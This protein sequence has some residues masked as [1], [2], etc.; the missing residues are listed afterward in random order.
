VDRLGQICADTLGP[1]QYSGVGG[2][3]DF[4]RGARLSEGGKAVIVL[5]STARNGQ[6]SRIVPTLKPESRSP[7]PTSART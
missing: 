6:V 7:I 3:V 2:Q 1:V 5:T 4:V